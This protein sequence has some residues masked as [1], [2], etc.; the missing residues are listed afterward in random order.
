MMWLS[1]LCP[2]ALIVLQPF[3]VLLRYDGTIWSI[4]NNQHQQQDDKLAEPGDLN[5]CLL[6]LRTWFLHLFTICSV[7]YPSPCYLIL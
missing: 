6:R 4:W 1:P 5:A 3:P 7:Y 2:K